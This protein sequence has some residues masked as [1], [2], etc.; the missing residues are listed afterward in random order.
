MPQ[1]QV[2]SDLPIHERQEEIMAAV[3]NHQVVVI[4]GETGSGKSTQ[5]PLMMMAAGYG[6]GGFIGHTQPR[7]IAA[8]GV[9]ARIAQQINSPIGTD[10]GFKI[11]FDDKTSEK[12]YVKLMTDG[13]LLAETQTDRFLEQYDMII[14][15]EAHERSLNIDFLLG[16]LKRILERR[17]DF[18]LVITSATIDTERFAEHFTVDEKNPVPIIDVE[19]RT[20]PVE[21][22][23]NPPETLA[24]GT[25]RD[26]EDHLVSVCE[27]LTRSDDGDMLI[28]LPTERDIRSAS[29]KLRAAKLTGRKTEILPLYARLSTDQQNQIFQP[30][31]ARRI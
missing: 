17:K 13:I 19:G 18:R 16:Y 23:Y 1:T 29:K 25:F 2:D 26:A 12:S 30:G 28:F 14:V 5:L 9:A 22:Q 7:R 4:S 3:R 24:D 21:I 10:V 8:R 27:E 20:F 11:R 6:V 15:D 31:K